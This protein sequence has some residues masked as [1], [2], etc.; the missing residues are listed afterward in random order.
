MNNLN[1]KLNK[2]E[3]NKRR[4]LSISQ[5][6]EQDKRRILSN[7][8]KER[9]L[10][11]L[12]RSDELKSLSINASEE[13][14]ELSRY[15]DLLEEQLNWETREY[16]L[17]LQEKFLKNKISIGEF[18]QA[19][20]ERDVLN[21][22]AAGMLESNFILLSPHKKSLDFSKLTD[23]ILEACYAYDPDAEQSSE[24]R[25]RKRKEFRDLVQT[26]YFEIQN[27]LKE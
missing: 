11:L 9:H 2:I 8:Q 26:I 10:E 15:S 7:Y 4:I 13:A 25:E 27:L 12:K 5:K 21:S 22:E 6:R 1:Q 20:P 18:C 3:Q 16:F 23:E 24:I 14:L 19:F 17:Q